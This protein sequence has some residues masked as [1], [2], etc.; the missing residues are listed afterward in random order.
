MQKAIDELLYEILK[1]ITPT[2]EEKAKIETLTKELEQKIAVACTKRGITAYIRAEGSVAKDTWLRENPDID[3]FMRLPTTIHKK[4]LGKLGI[5]IAREATEGTKQVERFAEHPYLEAFINGIRVNVVPCYAVKAGEW[6][7]ATDR[8]PF[9][10]DY[11][12]A[13]LDKEQLNQV[14]ILKKFMQGIKVY[15]AEIKTGGFSG[16]L[17][18]LL[19]LHYKSFVK[20]LTAFA[21]YKK[22]III[23]IENYYAENTEEISRT[24]TEPLIVIDPVDKARNAASAVQPQKLS[25]FIAAAREFL[26]APTAEFFKPAE[27]APLPPETIAQT[28]EK[29]GVT[30]IFLASPTPKAVPD[31]LWGQLY[32]TQRTLRRLMETNDFKILRDTIWNNEKTLNIFI[33]E[34]EQGKLPPVKKHLGPPLTKEKECKN[35]LKKYTHNTTEVIAGPYIEYNRW[36]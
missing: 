10:T 14:R 34:L 8:T 4:T 16:Y 33:L 3:I 36:A 26:Q 28:L 1:E 29:C 7:S 2:K 21:Q 23:D 24:F 11:I 5:E 19:I 18:E 27:I 31:V 13:H 9:H 15:G 32:K 25:T 30:Y 35:F 20:T 12:R 17:C 6:L 22:R